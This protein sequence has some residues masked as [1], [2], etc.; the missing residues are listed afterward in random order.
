MFNKAI[1]Y[2]EKHSK[3]MIKK[4]AASSIACFLF[5]SF[6]SNAAEA[7][8]SPVKIDKVTE[9]SLAATAD[10]MGTLHSRS[11][12]NITAG[13][14]GRLEWLQ[15]P[16]E[17]VQQGD[18]LAKMDLLPLQL[19]QAEQKAQI[20]RASINSRYFN[21][22]LQRLQKLKLTNSTS[23][24]QLDQ[25]KSQYELA[26][27]D[28]EIANLK[29]KQ[30]E[31]ELKRATVKAPFDGVVTERVVR[32]GTDINR[33]DILLKLLDTE[34]LEVRLYVPVKYLAYVRKG[35][36][37][38]LKAIGQ[39]ISTKVT[40]VIPSTDPLSQTFEVR[41]QIPQHLNEFW[42]AGQLVKVT[43]PIQDAH[44]SLTIHRDALILRKDG[45]FVVK[46]DAENKAHRLLVKVGKGTFDRVTIEGDLQS[47]DKIAIRGAERL[48]E[49][50]SVIV[51]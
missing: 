15:E 3:N 19:K 36:E 42:T 40:S 23:Q 50:Q 14:S 5:A 4:I 31:D 47:G 20:K 49:G 33:S 24:F 43:V 7:P 35:H 9:V 21:N 32:A 38:N 11:Y 28:I 12:V 22:E 26:Q 16:G 30:I 46:I 39:S 8:A 37:L 17:M 1:F 18:V 2:K 41:I 51:Q 13:V 6:L 44:P 29:L 48:R 10:L 45:T 27:A 34:N 25:T